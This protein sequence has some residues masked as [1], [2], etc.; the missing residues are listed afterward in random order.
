MPRSAA[1]GAPVLS[2]VCYIELDV[3]LMLERVA[4]MF[5]LFRVTIILMPPLDALRDDYAILLRYSF[6]CLHTMLSRR[7]ATRR[8]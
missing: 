4:V 2:A 5:T 6:F 8:V 1:S 3:T 7:D